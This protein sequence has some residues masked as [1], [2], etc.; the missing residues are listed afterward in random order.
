ML[1]D[2]PRGDES[3]IDER[4]E[5]EM[6]AV[7]ELI[8]KVRNIRAEMNIKPSDKPAIHVSADAET[9]KIFAENEA[10]ILKLA[11]VYRKFWMFR[12]R[13]RAAFSPEMS[14]LRFR[15]KV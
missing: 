5:S 15:S 1:S 7:I 2:F 8:S 4:A 11:R 13:R 14:R 12:K 3:L 9:R 10:R 6:Q